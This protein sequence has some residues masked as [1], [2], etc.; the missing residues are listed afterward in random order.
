MYKNGLEHINRFARNDDYTDKVQRAM[1]RWSMK[2]ARTN[3]GDG[4]NKWKKMALTK[5]DDNS[6][7]VTSL[8]KE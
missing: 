6:S 3:L 1:K 8:L 7:K 4:F 5:V 2:S